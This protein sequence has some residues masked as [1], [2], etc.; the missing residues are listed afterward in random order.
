MAGLLARDI[1]P[2]NQSWTEVADKVAGA[3]VKCKL[4]DARAWREAILPVRAKLTAPLARI[5]RE[6]GRP[7]VERRLQ[8][9]CWFTTRPTSRASSSICSWTPIPSRSTLL[10]LIPKDGPD[11]DGRL[12]RAITSA[13]LAVSPTGLPGK[14]GPGVDATLQAGTIKEAKDKHPAPSARAAVALVRFGYGG[15]VWHLLEYHEDPR[16]RSEGFHHRARARSELIRNCSQMS[17]RA[18]VTARPGINCNGLDH[19]EKRLSVRP[20]HVKAS[21]A[22]PGSCWMSKG[23]ARNRRTAL[24]G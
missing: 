2:A 4:D 8:P 17:S 14:A 1:V 21:R 9:R 6:T 15:E 22:D 12:R 23:V 20:H 7:D 19:R 10:P 13:P 11:R 18:R 24:P 3:L 16:A 5:Y